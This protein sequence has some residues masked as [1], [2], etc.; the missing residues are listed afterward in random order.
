MSGSSG[1]IRMQ[2]AQWSGVI[3]RS[4]GFTCE[5]S[6]TA[7]AQRGWNR[8]PDGGAMGDGTSPGRTAVTDGLVK[9][10][11]GTAAISARV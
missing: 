9:P 1:L 4:T 10:I 7:Y 8:Q 2:A 6:G 5:H 3:S 11:D